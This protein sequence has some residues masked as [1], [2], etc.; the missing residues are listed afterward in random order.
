MK[1][2]TILTIII[3]IFLLFSCKE[4]Q[5]NSN[6]NA[7]DTIKVATT[8]RDVNLEADLS[9]LSD[10]QKTMIKLFIRASELVDS[11]FFYENLDNFQKVIENI[12]DSATLKKFH[13][14]FGPWDRFAGNQPFING[15]GVKPAGGNFYPQNMSTMEFYEFKDSCKF[16][17]YT[18]L[19]RNEKGEL[20]CLP[21][22]IEFKNYIDTIVYLLNTAADLAEDPEFA[23]YLQERAIAMQNDDYYKSDSMWINLRNNKLDFIIGPVYVLD[24]KLF[25]IKAEHQSFIL[26]KDTIWTGKM[27]KYNKWLRFLQ[28]AI[29]VPEEYRAEEPGTNSS[30]VVY[31]ALYYGGSGKCG[32]TLISVVFPIDPK[33]QISQGIKNLQFKNIIKYKFDAVAKPLSEII[34]TDKQK[35]Y[36]TRDAFFVNTILYE[37]ANSLG[38]RNTINGNG[39]V[40]NALKNYFTISDYIKNYSLSLFLAD[41]LFE[42]GEIKNDLRE[43]YFTFVVDLVRLIRFGEENDYA[44]SNLVCYNYF[45]ENKAITYTR[46][47]TIE[48]NYEKMKEINTKLMQDIIIMQGNGDYSS[49]KQFIEK[50]NYIDDNLKAIINRINEQNVPTDIFLNQGMAVLGIE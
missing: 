14:N 42:V 32:G 18:F 35:P 20:Y 44:I 22:H 26:L 33:I 27:E 9:A 11:M 6:K 13:Y 45:V 5:H 37:M 4:T 23:K 3:G 48:I 12:T 50:Y 38:I 30:I 7:E 2:N 19:R 16:S 21:Y 24:D 8:I 49:M 17:P 28:K 46:D 15:F 1:K 43:N 29:P 31:D 34:L 41:K 47:G 10:N 36:V 25:N 40:R 39:T